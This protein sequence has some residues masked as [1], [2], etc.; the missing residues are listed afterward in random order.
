MEWEFLFIRRNIKMTQIK[1]YITWQ[2]LWSGKDVGADVSANINNNW[3]YPGREITC[4]E[5]PYGFVEHDKRLLAII[6]YPENVYEQEELDKMYN[7]ISSWVAI[8]IKPTKAVELCNEWYPAHEGED[9]YFELDSDGFTIVD[10]R[11]DVDY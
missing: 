11:P 4:I 7:S 10:N 6:E 8:K 3:N 5:L 2:R 9:P 1:Q